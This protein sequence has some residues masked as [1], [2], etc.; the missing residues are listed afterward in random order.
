MQ[1]FSV[2]LMVGFAL[3]DIVHRDDTH[4]SQNMCY[5]ASD[6]LYGRNYG[7][8][9]EGP[10]ELLTNDLNVRVIRARAEKDVPE[11]VYVEMNAIDAATLGIGTNQNNLFFLLPFRTLCVLCVLCARLLAPSFF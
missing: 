2:V 5:L 7:Q 8:S 11:D 9:F 1:A 10:F 6:D 4:Q 3:F